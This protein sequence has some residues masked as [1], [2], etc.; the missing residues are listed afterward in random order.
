MWF[1]EREEWLGTTDPATRDRLQAETSLARLTVPLITVDGYVES[2]GLVPDLIKI[3]T[4]GS[5]LQVLQGA[6]RTLTRCRPLVLFECW[7]AQRRPMAAFLDAHHYR[8]CSLP[9]TSA[10]PRVLSE[11]E[12]ASAELANFAAVPRERLEKWTAHRG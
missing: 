1:P 5:D 3:D 6:T 9:L 10:Q 8:I 4:E 12:F 2:H 11:T 7:Q